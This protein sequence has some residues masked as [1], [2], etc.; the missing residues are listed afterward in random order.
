MIGLIEMGRGR[1]WNIIT[2]NLLQFRGEAISGK[3][4]TLFWINVQQKGVPRNILQF[5]K[6]VH[7]TFA[8]SGACAHRLSV[9]E[10]SKLL[11]N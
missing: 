11:S 7:L 3:Y 5:S 6:Y 2:F 9:D 4:L 1:M 10:L 8:Y